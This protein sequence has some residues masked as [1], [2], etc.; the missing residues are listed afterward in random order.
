M[1]SIQSETKQATKI[2]YSHFPWIRL[3]QMV[4]ITVNVRHCECQTLDVRHCES[5]TLD[6]RHCESQTLDVRHCESLT[7]D[8]RHC[9]CLTLDVRHCECQTL[10]VRH[11]ESQTLDVRHCKCQTLCVKHCECQTPDV[12]HLMSDTVNVKH[13]MS[14]TVNVKHAP[15]IRHCKCQTLDIKHLMSSP[16]ILCGALLR[17]AKSCMLP[18]TK[19][20]QCQKLQKLFGWDSNGCMEQLARPQNKVK[21]LPLPPSYHHFNLQEANTLLCTATLTYRWQTPS[22]VLPL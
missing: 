3:L 9:E 12:K 17:Y 19:V 4:W 14:D 6:V 11:C 2:I 7:L 15:D 18:N 20:S 5:Q 10:D 22:S 1:K 8:V 21:M 13:L 16:S